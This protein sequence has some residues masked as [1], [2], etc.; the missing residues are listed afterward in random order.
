MVNIEMTICFSVRRASQKEAKA[1][2]SPSLSSLSEFLCIRDR[3]PDA[4]AATPAESH[5]TNKTFTCIL[6]LFRL[7]LGFLVYRLRYGIRIL[8]CLKRIPGRRYFG[9]N[10]QSGKS[11]L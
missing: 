5:K 7:C 3:S 4:A 2:A 6:L 1:S 9:S 8:Q 10:C 11:V